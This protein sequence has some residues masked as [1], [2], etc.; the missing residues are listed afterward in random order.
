MGYYSNCK[1]ETY[2]VKKLLF[3]LAAAPLALCG[4]EVP[5][6][7]NDDASAAQY[8]IDNA[9]KWDDAWEDMFFTN[10]TM[11][12]N[13]TYSYEYGGQS[14][15]YS[16]HNHLELNDDAILYQLDVDKPTQMDAAYVAKE[17]EEW[18]AYLYDAQTQ[19]YGSCD[20]TTQKIGGVGPTATVKEFKDELAKQATLS[21]SFKSCY[22]K[23]VYDEANKEYYC[24]SIIYMDLDDSVYGPNYNLAARKA[25]VKFE[26]GKISSISAFFVT[27]ETAD[28]DAEAAFAE[29]GDSMQ[30]SITKINSTVPAKPTNIQ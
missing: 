7:V 22:D 10:F 3:L 24:E 13:Y 18:K 6:D 2:I 30:F 21:I 15:S 23:F 12:V 27:L 1:K 29:A 11:D 19:T 4:C 8:I 9:E 5:E 26:K 16:G 25:H 20:P 17:G 28:A 14:Y